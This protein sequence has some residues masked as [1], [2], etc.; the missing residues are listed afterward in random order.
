MAG[1]QQSGSN[2]ITRYRFVEFLKTEQK[3]CL[4]TL[5][6]TQVKLHSIMCKL[7]SIL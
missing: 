7:L 1:K 5:H 4:E 2:W 6:A 3:Y